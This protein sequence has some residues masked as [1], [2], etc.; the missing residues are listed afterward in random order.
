MAKAKK[1]PKTKSRYN[2][3]GSFY[4]DKSK[5]RWYGV[6]TVGFDADD[7][8]I[9]KKVSDKSQPAALKKFDELK[10]QIRKGTYIDKDKSRLED[11]ILFQIEKDKSLNIINDNTYLS[12]QA[13]LKVIQK[14]KLGKMPVQMINETNLLMFF[15]SVTHY[16]QSYLKKIYRCINSALKYAQG[17]E[18]IYRNPLS[19]IKTP[20][21]KIAT[22]KVTALTIQEQK[23]FLEVLHN[24]EA[25]HKYR[26]I[27]E[28]ML[29]TGMRCGEVN[30]LDK[31]KD[32]IFDFNRITVRRTIT[33][34]IHA[35]PVIGEVPKTENGQRIITM[36]TACCSLLK[37]YIE[38]IWQPNK[39]NLLFYDNKTDKILTTSQVND[40]FNR[41]IVKYQIIPTHKELRPL[42][43]KNRKKIAYKP[44]TYYKKNADSFELLKKDAPKDWEKNFSKYYFKAVVSEKDFNLHMLR[45]TFATRCIES[46]M[47]AKVL[48][49]ILGHADIE[50]TLNT[51]CDVFEEYE[52]DALAKAEEYMQKLQLISPNTNAG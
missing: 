13:I 8:P 2:G 40:A 48:Q 36:N 50:T 16:S 14:Y 47:P 21:S 34:D 26:Y 25:N 19:Q 32:I 44:Y 3:E 35:K 20:K 52:N 15:N 51:Y 24:E 46:G 41:L 37:T 33:K 11:I 9:R 42:S 45:H 30:A 27:F 7:K 39:E 49:K 23:R 18:I 29:C 4:F 17:K 12:R 22:K 28:L 6:V 10:E 5:G 38:N 31:N 1:E 43:E